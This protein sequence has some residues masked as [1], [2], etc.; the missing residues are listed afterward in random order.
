MFSIRVIS[1]NRSASPIIIIIG[2]NC[3]GFRFGSDLVGFK[4]GIWEQNSVVVVVVAVA[5]VVVKER[6][7]SFNGE[8]GEV[9]MR[10]S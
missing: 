1:G 10:G 9:G 8:F 2:G 6:V 5:V 4:D 3:F 7:V